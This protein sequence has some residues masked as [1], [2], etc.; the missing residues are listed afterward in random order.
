MK[1]KFAVKR[2]VSPVSVRSASTVQTASSLDHSA[3]VARWQ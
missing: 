3:R 1:M 2:T